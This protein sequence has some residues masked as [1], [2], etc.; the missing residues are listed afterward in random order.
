[1]ALIVPQRVQITVMKQ[2]VNSLVM[3]FGYLKNMV[4]TLFD[5]N[6]LAVDDVHTALGGLADQY[7]AL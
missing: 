1:M 4:Y 3:V 5:N 7:A 2:V 6:F